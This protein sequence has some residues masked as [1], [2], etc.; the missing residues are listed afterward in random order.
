M[1]EGRYDEAFAAI[2][3]AMALAPGDADN[4][5]VRAK[6]LNAIGRAGEAEGEV[7]LAM[8]LDPRVAPAT[9]RVLSTTL[10][11]LQRY[12]EAVGVIDQIKAQG[13]ATSD[14]Y[15]TLVSALGHL[16]RLDEVP[17]A[18]NGY[19]A[20]AMPAAYDPMSIAEIESFWF[21]DAFDY[22]R[23]YVADLVA[24]LKKTSLRPGAGA[25][26]P[27]ERYKPL[28][29]R[30]RGEYSV[31]GTTKVDALTAKALHE[32]GVTFV[33]LR[34]HLDYAN[35]HIPGAV[36]L[37]LFDDLSA[38]TLG[39]VVNPDDEV[40]FYCHGKYCGVSAHG[41]AKGV[42]WGWKHIY[43]FAGGFPAWADAGYAVE[44]SP[45]PPAR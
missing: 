41:S 14:D 18:I 10:F 19:N 8:R 4:H 45:E 16:G 7:R 6:L 35:G 32:R 42:A 31:Q 24:G 12:G 15:M 37:S 3:K 40:I 30:S 17:A 5:A 34:A 11:H 43:Y 44:A 1:F 27:L 21:G 9:L 22:Y 25:D 29:A 38:E 20:L 13:S 23:P 33:D 2:D 36:N 39:A 26:M 28:M